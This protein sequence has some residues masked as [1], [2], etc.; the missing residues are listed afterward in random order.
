MTVREVGGSEEM[1]ERV[2]GLGSLRRGQHRWCYLIYV[3][4]LKGVL[5][6]PKVAEKVHKVMKGVKV[7]CR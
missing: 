2:G 6:R 7:C 5:L 1:K 4:Y 3:N